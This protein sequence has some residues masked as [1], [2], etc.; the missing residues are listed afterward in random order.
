[1]LIGNAHYHCFCVRYVASEKLTLMLIISL[2]VGLGVPLII[3]GIVAVIFCTH[4]KN[5]YS[6]FVVDI[7]GYYSHQLPDEQELDTVGKKE[8]HYSQQLPEESTYL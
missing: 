4:R 1:M 2:S 8:Q 3:V 5:N 7:D 6:T